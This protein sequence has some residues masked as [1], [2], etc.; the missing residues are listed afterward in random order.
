MSD[1]Q[2]PVAI[3]IQWIQDPTAVPSPV[4]QFALV[5]GP[6]I[7]GHT[8]AD[9]YILT[10]GHMTPPMLPETSS[11]EEMRAMLANHQFL[12]A[13]VGLFEFTEPRLR[14]LRDTLNTFFTALDGSA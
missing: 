5:G 12:V 4:N 2:G 6:N 14:N 13:P 9:S 8:R 11:P 10:F 7:E 1:I 3:N